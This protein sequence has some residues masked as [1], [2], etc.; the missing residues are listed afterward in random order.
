[1]H[2]RVRRESWCTT[3]FVIVVH[4]A[5]PGQEAGYDL[6]IS[7]T[8]GG[9]VGSRLSGA[10]GSDYPAVRLRAANMIPSF[11]TSSVAFG[12][13][14][15][16]GL[17]RPDIVWTRDKLPRK[18]LVRGNEKSLGTLESG[19][20]IYESLSHANGVMSGPAS[21]D[22]LKSEITPTGVI[23]RTRGGWNRGAT[24]GPPS[25]DRVFSSNGNGNGNGGNREGGTALTSETR[26]TRR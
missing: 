10:N 18:S 12:S 3:R 7:G 14:E 23:F 2:G 5:V 8:S 4:H 6:P 1:M 16:S 9:V 20:T 25:K 11:C 26:Y 17:G 24:S 21:I 13:R 15:A 19:Q 22:H